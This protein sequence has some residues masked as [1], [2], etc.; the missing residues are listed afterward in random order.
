MIPQ[1]PEG[2]NPE[3]PKINNESVPETTPDL[4]RIL[5]ETNLKA[6]YYLESWK[7]S[8][9]DFANYKRRLEQEKLETEGDFTIAAEKITPEAVNFMARYGRGLICL[10]MTGERLDELHRRRRLARLV[11]TGDEE[12][13]RG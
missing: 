8:Q 3:I 12:N 6:D 7:R 4:E 10:A 13:N 9:A 5:A 2:T 1:E 11:C